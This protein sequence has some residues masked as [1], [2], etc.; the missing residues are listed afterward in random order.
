MVLEK[1]LE[2]PL[3]RKEIQPV[4]PKGN[5]CW[6]FTG[7]TDA[8]AE[9]PILWSL[10]AKNWLIGKDPDAGKDWRWEEKGMTG[11]DDW[12]AS[13]T[14]WTWVWV[15]SGSWWWTG[16]P[17]VLLSMGLQRVSWTWLS[18]WTELKVCVL[19]LVAQLCLTLCDLMDYSLQG[20][21][22]DG[23]SPG[24]NTGVGCC[25]LLQEIF[26]TQGSNPGL[27]H[28]RWILCHL[29]HQGCPL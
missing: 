23:D 13:S 7:R 8:E 29:S 18:D 12:M 21:S 1:T 16:R 22:V 3:D 10:D 27:L 15:N 11:W 20:S 19:C 5:Q 26:Q 6:I 28:C 2:N 25:A 9:T 24:K 4:H 14:R 17:G